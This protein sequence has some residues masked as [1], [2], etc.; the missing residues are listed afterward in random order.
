MSYCKLKNIWTG[1]SKYDLSGRKNMENIKETY[2]PPVTLSLPEWQQYV[3]SGN[4][5]L[6]GSG[7]VIPGGTKQMPFGGGGV[8]Y[9][10]HM[11]QGYC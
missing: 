4:N 2:T 8:V 3:A 10:G 5:V 6:L 9:K 11:R 7:G 1:L